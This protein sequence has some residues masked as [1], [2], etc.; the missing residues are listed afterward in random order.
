MKRYVLIRTRA[1]CATVDVHE[2]FNDGSGE[3]HYPLRHLV[4]HSPT[5]IEWGYGGSGP[6]DL[7]RSIVGD[8]L[9]RTDPNPAVYQQLKWDYLVELPTEGGAI[10]EQQVREVIAGV[11]KEMAAL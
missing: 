2:T 5:G 8:L 10:T 6:S 9:G 1:G 3:R 11:E 7:A 4:H